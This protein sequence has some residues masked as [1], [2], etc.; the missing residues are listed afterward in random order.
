MIVQWVR[1]ASLLLQQPMRLLNATTELASL[2][3]AMTAADYLPLALYNTQG[4]EGKDD[5]EEGE[6]LCHAMMSQ[7]G[8][9]C[10]LPTP[11]ARM[12]WPSLCLLCP[13]RVFA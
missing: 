13:G 6:E 10:L 1:P 9:C 8:C 3:A 12:C 11:R 2:A 5:G 4:A 7:A